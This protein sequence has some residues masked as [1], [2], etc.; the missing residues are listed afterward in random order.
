MCGRYGVLDTDRIIQ[1]VQ[2]L[3]GKGLTLKPNPDVR[4]S[5]VVP[6]LAQG[7]ESKHVTWGIQ[8]NSAKRP[9]INAKGKT[10]ATKKTFAAPSE[11]IAAWFLSTAGMNGGMKAAQRSSNSESNCPPGAP[12]LMAGVWFPGDQPHAGRRYR[13]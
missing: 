4:P 9:L 3:G 10:V 8:P 1:Y 11:R 2:D 12:M 5:N 13:D 6:V 7:L